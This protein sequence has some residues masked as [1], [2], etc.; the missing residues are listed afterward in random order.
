MENF[1]I[2][3]TPRKRILFFLILAVAALLPLAAALR[4]NTPL[5]GLPSVPVGRLDS[6]WL[7]RDVSGLRRWRSC[8]MSWR[9]KGM[10]WSWCAI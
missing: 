9:W 8:P 5:S 6:G 4:Y 3:S 2:F 1:T 7:Y 10:R